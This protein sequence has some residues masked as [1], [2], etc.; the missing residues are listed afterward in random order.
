MN[1][2]ASKKYKQIKVKIIG[3]K[4]FLAKTERHE[5][6]ILKPIETFHTF[7]VPKIDTS[8]SNLSK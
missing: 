4:T 6:E 5:I 7:C 1:Y 2:K 8:F 3:Q